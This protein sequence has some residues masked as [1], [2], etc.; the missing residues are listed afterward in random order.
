V[1]R[2]FDP[3]RAHVKVKKVD[4]EKKFPGE[5]NFSIVVLCHKRTTHLRSVLGALSL[6][7]G[8]EYAKVIFVAHD[9]PTAVLEIID[10]FPFQ[11][12]TLLKVEKRNFSSPSHAINHNLFMG[13]KYAFAV[14]KS[15]Y[16]CVIE[17]DVVLSEDALEFMWSC[18][19]KFGDRRRFRGINS[20]SLNHN[21]ESAKGDVVKINYGLGQG[22]CINK[23]NYSKILKFWTG[24]E[25][26]H[27]DYFIEP[28]VRTGFVI[29]PIYSRVKNIGF[30]ASGTHTRRADEFSRL[31]ELSFLQGNRTAKSEIR[32]VEFPLSHIR[33]DLIV[34]SNLSFIRRE[35]LYFFRYLSFKLYLLALAGKP[36]IHYLWRVSRNFIDGKF[37]NVR[38]NQN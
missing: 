34:L 24:S 5:A 22:W 17:D 30:D 7:S 15:E 32:E 38:V 36:R 1:G 29:A 26:A 19:M 33:G 25:H 31:V 27:W 3:D 4:T 16:C 6:C 9:S 2:R 20:Y 18:L 28:F 23:K 11:E 12:K 21:E 14:N 8:V 10:Q 13:L 37:S 35:L